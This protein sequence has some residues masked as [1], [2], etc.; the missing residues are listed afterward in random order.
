[1][2]FSSAL[3]AHRTPHTLVFRFVS[4]EIP[5]GDLVVYR[6]QQSYMKKMYGK[7]DQS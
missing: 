2:K 1:M 3:L 4:N 5:N 6:N 7:V